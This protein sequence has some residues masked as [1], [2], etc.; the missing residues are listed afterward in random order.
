MIKTVKADKNIMEKHHTH[1][2]YHYGQWHH[3]RYCEWRPDF[4]PP[5]PEYFYLIEGKN[6][7]LCKI[8]HD[9]VEQNKEDH[10]EYFEHQRL[11]HEAYLK[12]TLPDD[13]VVKKLRQNNKVK[14]K[15]I[16]K[17]LLELKRANLK[18]SYAIEQAKRPFKICRAHGNLKIEDCIKSGKGRQGEQQYKC[19]ACMK[20]IHKKHYIKNTPKV[21]LKTQEYR[22]KNPEKVAEIHRNYWLKTKDDTKQQD[23]AR[24]K[25]WAIANKDKIQKRAKRLK[26]YY[27]DELQDAY[28]KQQLVK[29]TG[30]KHSDIP[31]AL[32][33]LK[34]ATMLV[35]RSIYQTKESD[36]LLKIQEKLDDRKNKKHKPTEG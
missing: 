15:D 31:K 27:V 10:H 4:I 25:K 17:D 9:R 12:E 7:Y 13:Y 36:Y 11:K 23:Y 29:G 1:D 35:K 33:D 26:A 34:R 24:R 22:L 6:S 8:C 21:L 16:T 14:V 32:V 30:L 28:V 3:S 5:N 18:L 2:Y 19:R 20:D